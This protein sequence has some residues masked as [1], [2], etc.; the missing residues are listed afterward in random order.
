MRRVVVIGAGPVGIAAAL[1]AIRRGHETTVLEAGEVGASLRTWGPTR[2]FTPLAMNVTRD[3]RDAAALPQ[4]DALLTGPEY[5]DRVLVPIVRRDPLRSRLRTNTRVVAISRRGLTRVDYAG[6]PLRAEKPFHILTSDDDIIEGDVILDATGSSAIP[7]PYT[8][9]GA[10]HGRA[11]R[12]LGEVATGHFSGMRV[13]LVGHG[14][15][16]ANALAMLRERGADITWAVRTPKQKPCEEIANDPLPERQRVVSVAN[17]AA[18]QI[19]VERRA[20]IERVVRSNGHVDITLSGGRTVQA[21]AIVALTGYRPSSDFT[22]ELALEI[23]PVNEG[24]ARLYRAISNITDCL[25]TP[26]VSADDL[27]SGEPNYFFVGARAYGRSRTFLLQT[28][29]QQLDTILD[30]IS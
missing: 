5:A 19:R 9:R 2:F 15:S 26:R 12:T 27:A 23:S 20:M 16:A 7:L 13:L 17:D 29:F 1:G 10:S 25:T 11:I 6:H 8:A 30:S 3:M 14:H 4:D 18:S 28:G 21:D 22:S 24:G